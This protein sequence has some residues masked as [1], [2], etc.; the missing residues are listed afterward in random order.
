MI[1]LFVILLCI[2]LANS[3]HEGAPVDAC[4]SMIPEHDVSLSKCQP[5]YL[6]QADKLVFGPNDAVRSKSCHRSDWQ[7]GIIRSLLDFSVTV[8]GTTIEDRFKGIL[9]TAKNPT[10]QQI[11]GAWSLQDSSLQT[12]ACDKVANTAVTHSSANEKSQIEAVWHAPDRVT[13][14]SVIIKYQASRFAK[15]TMILICV[16]HFPLEQRSSNRTMRSTWTV[17]IWHWLRMWAIFQGSW[18]TKNL[19]W[20]LA[21]QSVISTIGSK[22][23]T[24]SNL[25]RGQNEGV[26]D[27]RW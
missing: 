27:V 6:I 12:L 16:H 24:K 26:V 20:T 23:T 4:R 9:L 11:L 7:L 17:S 2:Q 18:S 13:V 3:H 8:R 15:W 19:W 5:K 21:E 22:R 14:Q 25:Y 10:N 1:V